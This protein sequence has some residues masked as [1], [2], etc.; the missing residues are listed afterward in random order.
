MAESGTSKLRDRDRYAWLM[1]HL[2]EGSSIE[3]HR[4]LLVIEFEEQQE[5]RVAGAQ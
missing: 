2:A 5:V 4:L 1:S 3:A